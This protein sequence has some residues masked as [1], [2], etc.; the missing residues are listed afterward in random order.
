MITVMTQ[1][2]PSRTARLLERELDE[3]NIHDVAGIVNW[4]GGNL[5]STLPVLNRR[6]YTD[7]LRQL[8]QLHEA[9][10]PVPN[11]TIGPPATGEPVELLPRSR[12]HQQGRDFTRRR[13]WVADFYVQRYFFPDEWRIHVFKTNKGNYRVI[14]SGIKLPKPGHHPW[15]KSHRLGWYISYTGGAPDA[16]KSA[17]RE[18]VRC[19]GLDFGCVDIGIRETGEP[20]LLEVN[21]APG[22]DT[23]TR[24][25]YV[26]NILERLEEANAQV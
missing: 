16:A 1:G 4:T 7:K 13:P 2:R 9:G 12:Y 22:L 20:I 15:V 21:T 6:A 26:N 11:F 17:A 14:R 3:E 18:G 8:Q 23:G 5:V 10:V 19:L 25:Y 24:S